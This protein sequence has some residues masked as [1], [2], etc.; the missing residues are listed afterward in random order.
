MP[1]TRLRPYGKA[2][3]IDNL[4]LELVKPAYYLGCELPL[5]SESKHLACTASNSVLP[6]DTMQERRRNLEQGA[7]N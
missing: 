3:R 4:C 5:I 2:P 1:C 7:L 6:L